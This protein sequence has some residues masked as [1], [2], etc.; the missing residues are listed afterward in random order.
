M[1]Q[2]E[3]YI[4]E[5]TCRGMMLLMDAHKPDDGLARPPSG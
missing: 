3:I 2:A 4:G 1:K 5:G